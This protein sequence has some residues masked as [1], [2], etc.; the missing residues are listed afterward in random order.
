MARGSGQIE[1][2]DKLEGRIETGGREE[3]ESRKMRSLKSKIVEKGRKENKR[4]RQRRK[5]KSHI[6]LSSLGSKP[7]SSFF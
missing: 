7:T 1:R 3:E 4:G 6:K 5:R 2:S